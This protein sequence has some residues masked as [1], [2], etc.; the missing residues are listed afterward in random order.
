MPPAP[1]YYEPRGQLG[2]RIALAVPVGAA[3]GVAYAVASCLVTQVFEAP[4]L[5]VLVTPLFGGALAAASRWVADRAQVRSRRG[6]LALAVVTSAIALYASWQ[7]YLVLSDL[8]GLDFTPTWAMSPAK[9]G[10]GLA[11]LA[12]R[13]GR[14]SWVWWLAEVAIVESMIVYLMR[15]VDIEV[16]F[17][18]RCHAWAQVVVTF[19]LADRETRTAEARLLAGDAAALA[20]M[21]PRPSGAADWA[22]VRVY[23][24]ECGR[25]RHASLDRAQR[26][27]GASAGVR[28]YHAIGRRP[29]LYFDLGSSATTALTPIVTN[30]EI[31]ERTEQALAAARDE[32]ARRR[33]ADTDGEPGPTARIG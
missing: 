30:L 16:P 13:N 4:P 26:E 19:E 2:P 3:L 6:R 10:H 18:E 12:S 25:S 28:T 22:V 8:P 21:T 29:S 27:A 11:E 14:W 31:D 32:L 9:L 15:A 1:V 17:C 5:F 7:A 33:R 23:R 24:C 20:T